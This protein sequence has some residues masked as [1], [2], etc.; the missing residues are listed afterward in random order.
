MVNE[1]CGPGE[2]V[3]TAQAL[4]RRIA[5]NAPA[6]QAS[7]AVLRDAATMSDDDAFALSNDA[8]RQL[9][10]RGLRRRPSCLHRE[11]GSPVE[12]ALVAARRQVDGD[13]QQARLQPE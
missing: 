13:R 3:A 9:D 8:I 12:R 4:A 7:L 11:A 2:A 10:D 5:V 6:V 1:L